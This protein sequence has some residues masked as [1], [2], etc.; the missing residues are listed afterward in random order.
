MRYIILLA[1][2]FLGA[3]QAQYIN[4]LGPDLYPRH[5]K[6]WRVRGAGVLASRPATCTA[7]LDVYIC[8]GTGCTN[9]ANIHYCRATDTWQA[10]SGA[11]AASTDLSDTANIARLDA[12]NAFTNANTI[13]RAAIGTTPTQALAARNLTVAAA[14]AQ[15]YSPFF[16]WEGQGWK[17]AATA[18]SQS[19]KWRSQL[20]PVEGSANPSARLDFNYSINAGAYATTLSLLNGNVGI[21]STDFD[22][23]PAI[24]RL[25]VKGTTN[26]GST[27][28]LVLRDSDE[29]NVLSVDTNGIIT[30]GGYKSND[31]T[32]GATVTTCTGFKNGLCIS[33]T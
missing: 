15:Q 12:A 8:I 20:V 14:G 32:T 31:G 22:G 10:Q 25:I 2:L 17:T 4:L 19:V 6:Q 18:A 7:N 1:T 11:V 3:A 24:A 30:P 29:A 26:D 16:E 5:Q 27:N 28:I 23:T 9:G 13:T 21:G 33:G